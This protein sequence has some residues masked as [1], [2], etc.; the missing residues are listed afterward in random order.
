LVGWPLLLV[1]AFSLGWLYL[2]WADH[3]YAGTARGQR[4]KTLDLY[5]RFALI[6]GLIGTGV[7]T[8]VVDE[9]FGVAT[10]PKWL[11]AKVAL[12]GVAMLC[13]VLIRFRLKPF[14]P[15][16]VA[17]MKTGTAPD[18]EA[19]IGG[20]LRRAEPFVFGIWA[21]VLIIAALG[22]LKPGALV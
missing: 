12:Y 15:A 1:W 11:G 16:F 4:V 19:G 5:I 3:Q 6:V 14:G 8:M 7:Y 21:L 22:V 2:V 17:L 9:P 10:N 13:G 20:A 18:V